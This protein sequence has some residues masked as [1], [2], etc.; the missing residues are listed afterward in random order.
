M[1]GREHRL[2]KSGI[3]ITILLLLSVALPLGSQASNSSHTNKDFVAITKIT[4]CIAADIP[5]PCKFPIAMEITYKL[6][7]SDKGKLRVGIFLRQP[8]NKAPNVIKS[9]MGALQPLLP[10][11]EKNIV[12][13]TN[14]VTINTDT[15]SLPKIKSHNAQL[16]VVVNVHNSAKKELCWA[17]SYNFLRGSIALS[18]SSKAAVRDSIQLVNYAPDPKVG[19]LSTGKSYSFSAQ[20]KY[21]VRSCPWAF[22]N[23]ELCDYDDGTTS[24]VW[25][26]V[27]VPLPKGEGTVRVT[28]RDFFFPVSQSG[29]GLVLSI[30]FRVKPLGGTANTLRV[31]PW[32]LQRPQK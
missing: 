26:K 23:L 32:V 16:M 10:Y 25:H 8:G 1:L 11:I 24:G 29:R 12:K 30:P 20:L 31:G 2:I 27:A 9:K 19:P 15:I 17:T 7:T 18:P 5:T 4:P 3:V 6:A 21:S 28:T 22:A 14:T 13:G